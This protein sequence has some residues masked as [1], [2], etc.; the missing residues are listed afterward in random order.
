M[1]TIQDI[2]TSLK[3]R[4]AFLHSQIDFW[5]KQRDIELENNHTSKAKQSDEFVQFYVTRANEVALIYADINDIDWVDAYKVL[6]GA[7]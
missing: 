3:G 6:R 1:K 4:F 2:N 5:A 7:E